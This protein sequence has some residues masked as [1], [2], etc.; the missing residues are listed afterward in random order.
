MGSLSGYQTAFWNDISKLI[1]FFVFAN[2][3]PQRDLKPELKHVGA[4]IKFKWALTFRLP[5][6]PLSRYVCRKASSRAEVFNGLTGKLANGQTSLLVA[7]SVLVA[8]VGALPGDAV[9]GQSP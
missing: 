9:A 5:V 3:I 4:N 7:K 8:A 1:V 2:A 6:F